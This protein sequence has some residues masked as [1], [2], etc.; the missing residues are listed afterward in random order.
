MGIGTACSY[1]GEK[2]TVLEAKSASVKS[3]EALLGEK[4]PKVEKLRGLTFLLFG[5]V[6][7]AKHHFTRRED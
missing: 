5:L 3:A 6:R 1:D 7:M 2:W 4:L